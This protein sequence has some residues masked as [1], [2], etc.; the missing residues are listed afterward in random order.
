MLP[1]PLPF[2]RSI[3]APVM[4]IAGAK[5]CVNPFFY[6]S[7]ALFTSVASRRRVAVLVEDANHPQWHARSPPAS[8]ACG[9]MLSE[10]SQQAAGLELLTAFTSYLEHASTLQGR[11]PD[12]RLGSAQHA[13]ASAAEGVGSTA[14]LERAESEAWMRL[15]QT[16]ARGAAEGRWAYSTDP[17]EPPR[18]PHK[19]CAFEAESPQVRLLADA[20][21]VGGR[22][23]ALTDGG[24]ECL[25]VSHDQIYVPPGLTKI[26]EYTVEGARG[27]Q[28]H[29]PTWLECSPLGPQFF[30]GLRSRVYAGNVQDAAACLVDQPQLYCTDDA[31][32]SECPEVGPL[33]YTLGRAR[34][35]AD[36]DCVGR[37][38]DGQPD[39]SVP[40]GPQNISVCKPL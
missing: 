27:F 15:V 12:D 13:S 31:G 9:T 34:M 10:H 24:D 26:R 33:S 21:F 8:A 4:I 23:E 16:L 30:H 7:H 29:G 3:T 37:S 17:A 25:L 38:P 18:P 39:G 36:F 20:G 35:Y 22:L 2:A 5:D 1:P 14:T 19:C 28:R 32:R 40:W 6:D 11:A